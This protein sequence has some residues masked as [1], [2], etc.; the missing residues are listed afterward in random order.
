MEVDIFIKRRRQ[1]I[2]FG[3]V[4]VAF[5]LMS[6]NIT[7][8]D[9]IK[10][11]LSIPKAVVWMVTNFYPNAQSMAKLP[12]ILSKL[13]ETI[14]LSIAATTSASIFA[15]FFGLMGSKTTKLNGT[16]S[17][18]SRLIGSIS[19]NIPDV[20]WAMLL[21]FSFGQNVVTG[22]LALFFVTFGTLTRAFIET[23]DEASESAVE[24]LRATGANYF[25]IVFQAVIPSSIPQMLSWILYMIE[26]N[27]RSATL[28]GMLT[29]T[30]IGFAFNLYYKNLN[31]HTASLVVL[32]IV[33][34]V[35]ILEGISNYVRRV[36]L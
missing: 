27:I 16:L 24:A 30:G 11:I 14:F 6:S 2:L 34:S 13:H 25:Q 8:Y 20:V 17:T 5:T 28:I 29:G 36:I 1:Y 23:I 10:G 3:L 7:Q 33:L 12:D 22:Y 19:R 15:L 31:Y 32:V 4:L 18:L 9:P 21:L 35:L 26:T